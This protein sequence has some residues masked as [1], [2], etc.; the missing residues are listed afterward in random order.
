MKDSVQYLA[1]P[2]SLCVVKTQQSC[3]PLG[4]SLDA[5]SD[6][7]PDWFQPVKMSHTNAHVC[8]SAHPTLSQNLLRPSVWLCETVALCLFF[9]FSITSL[10]LAARAQDGAEVFSLFSFS[11]S[12]SYSSRT[13]ELC[14]DSFVSPRSL[15]RAW[16]Y[17][18][19]VLWKKKK[20]LGASRRYFYKGW[21]VKMPAATIERSV[22]LHLR[23]IREPQEL[24]LIL[25]GKLINSTQ[26]NI[27]RP[28]I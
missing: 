7:K 18:R 10:F 15:H 22:T 6:L 2:H 5:A 27:W 1:N 28:V 11:F 4:C 9:S 26:R 13:L 20:N 25:E 14:S 8:S 24:G 12:F 19:T 23:G 21:S 17:G 16:T 3:P